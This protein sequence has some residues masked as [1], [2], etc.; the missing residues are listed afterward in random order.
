MSDNCFTLLGSTLTADILLCVCNLV[1]PRRSD[2]EINTVLPPLG[3]AVK[4]E[5]LF[6]TYFSSTKIYTISQTINRNF[7]TR[8]LNIMQNGYIVFTHN[9]N[10]SYSVPAS[11]AG[12]STG[13]GRAENYKEQ[14]LSLLLLLVQS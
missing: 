3:L 10:G 5:I 4:P 13:I 8:N 1:R 11:G 2:P 9:L 6:H 7:M 12:P 14:C